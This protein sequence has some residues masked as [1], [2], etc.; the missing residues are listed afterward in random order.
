[1]IECKFL[2]DSMNSPRN[3]LSFY[4]SINM[5]H[6]DHLSIYENASYYLIED[7]DENIERF[8][9]IAEKIWSI[10]GI[11]MFIVNLTIFI[12][13]FRV[14]QSQK[15]Y[16]LMQVNCIYKLLI[17][18]IY[19]FLNDIACVYCKS[20]FYNSLPVLIYKSYCATTLADILNVTIGATEAL[21]TLDRLSILDQSLGNNFFR[22]QKIK[23]TMPLVILIGIC[24]HFPDFF[25]INIIHIG[26][27]LFFRELNRFSNSSSY[28]YVC[29]PI[30]TLYILGLAA[31]YLKLVISLLISYN[32]FLERKRRLQ[33]GTNAK[34]NKHET[35]LIKLILFQSCFN[36]IASI[37]ATSSQI[38]G[39]FEY[40]IKD[41]N[42]SDYYRGYLVIVGTACILLA[43]CCLSISDFAIFAY[44]SRIRG[45]FKREETPR[46]K[47][48]D[49]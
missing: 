4:R 11:V 45:L 13:I 34:I 17:G 43:L 18:L 49:N 1:M 40:K 37:A 48:A 44:D 32:Q 20:N 10:F 8:V 15:I 7:V 27:G 29:I 12:L 47:K 26:D 25:I 30:R 6:T 41:E 28:N 2:A 3:S 36:V 22:R 23:C 5:N 31:I 42:P 46:T 21:T 9:K 35:D 24:I 33:K 38:I 14:N 19:T 39:R 16:H